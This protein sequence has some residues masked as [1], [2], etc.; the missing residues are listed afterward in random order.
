MSDK[1]IEQMVNAVESGFSPR[2]VW[3]SSLTYSPGSTVK[4]NKST[5]AV[6][7]VS[8][9]TFTIPEG[10]V[11]SILGVGGGKTG[12]DHH[13]VTKDGRQAFINYYDLGESELQQ[14]SDEDDN[15]DSIDEGVVGF[16]KKVT[17][18][19]P[20]P[21]SATDWLTNGYYDWGVE[22]PDMPSSDTKTAVTFV[23]K[24]RTQSA[25]DAAVAT[26]KDRCGSSYKSDADATLEDWAKAKS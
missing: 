25:M 11:V 3:E 1:M 15:K 22:L 8:G 16:V 21:T 10:E 5:S 6:D 23:M 7:A 12:N 2:S 19:K 9:A 20:L 4:V 24:A 13:I 17:L 26:L 14:S 18:E